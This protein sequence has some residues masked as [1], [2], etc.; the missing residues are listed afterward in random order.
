M[1]CLDCKVFKLAF[2]KSRSSKIHYA[3]T[4]TSQ[5]KRAIIPRITNKFFRGETMFNKP[6][7]L[8]FLTC[9]IISSL[10]LNACGGTK[11]T[12]TPA[13]AQAPVSTQTPVAAATDTPSAPA[14]KNITIVIPE[15]PPS[16]N[17][18]IAYT[19]YDAMVMK[20]TLLGITGIDPNGKIYPEL[21]AEL[22]TLANG[23][24]V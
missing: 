20:M 18:V 13:A 1:H 14:N 23:G 9:V 8:F 4:L 19:G 22:P 21:A 10:L 15:D 3:K 5:A 16:F 24:V 7:S 11:V 17:A 6:R 2:Q 12:S